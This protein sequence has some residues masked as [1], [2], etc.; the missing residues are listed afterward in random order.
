MGCGCGG[1]KNSVKK[2][3]NTKSNELNKKINTEIKNNRKVIR[4]S[5]KW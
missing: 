2:N 4:R 5:F 3:V 1:S